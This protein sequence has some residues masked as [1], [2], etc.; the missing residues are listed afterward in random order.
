MPPTQAAVL[1]LTTGIGE[2]LILT[3]SGAE[4]ALHPDPMI[5]SFTTTVPIPGA[6]HETWMLAVPCPLS[7][8]PPVMVHL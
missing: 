7:K 3:L 5:E 4:L 1:P 6:S 2:L 8:V